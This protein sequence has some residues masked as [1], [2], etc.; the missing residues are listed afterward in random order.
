MDDSLIYSCLELFHGM[1]DDECYIDGYKFIIDS[2]IDLFED[3]SETSTYMFKFIC[4]AFKDDFD[5]EEFILEKQ[6]NI[7]EFSDNGCCVREIAEELV[8]FVISNIYDKV[9]DFL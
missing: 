5:I 7:D 3:A 6:I 1:V 2:E 9:E 4:T 8:T